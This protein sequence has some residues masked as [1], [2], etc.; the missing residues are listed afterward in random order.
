MPDRP[1][2]IQLPR[3][4]V[5]WASDDS[6]YD[7][8]DDSD[9]VA[10]IREIREG[11]TL[12]EKAAPE[13]GR[14][15]YLREGEEG[16]QGADVQ[17]GQRGGRFFVPDGSDAHREWTAGRRK[18]ARARAK[19]E[20]RR[21]PRPRDLSAGE[22]M[23]LEARPIAV[24]GG[25][26]VAKAAGKAMGR[27]DGRYAPFVRGM[28]DRQRAAV[29]RYLSRDVAAVAEFSDGQYGMAILDDLDSRE[30]V[31]KD[32]WEPAGG[33]KWMDFP[34]D[35]WGL[36]GRTYQKMKEADRAELECREQVHRWVPAQFYESWMETYHPEEYDRLWFSQGGSMTLHGQRKE[37]EGT[38]RLVAE[39]IRREGPSP[40]SELEDA[41]DLATSVS[42]RFGGRPALA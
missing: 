1:V 19:L 40:Q 10:A 7:L 28:R 24:R 9:M 35:H 18:A 16:P 14:R 13:D 2:P 29:Q 12:E 32:G 37:W 6:E 31:F 30:L 15:T 25:G 38:V 34:W 8:N 27:D 33:G 20:L 41:M 23:E 5:P 4:V 42:R 36:G 11:A 17:T 26:K 21:E 22:L 3:G 39:R